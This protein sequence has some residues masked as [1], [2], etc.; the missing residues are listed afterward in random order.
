MYKIHE[1]YFTKSV[2]LNV[3]E[4]TYTAASYT[5]NGSV[6][7]GAFIFVIY[8]CTWSIFVCISLDYQSKMI[9]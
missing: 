2:S 3:V 7:K 9:I 5:C 4:G 8:V 6:V 1:T